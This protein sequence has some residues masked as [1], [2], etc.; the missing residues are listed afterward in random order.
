MSSQFECD[1]KLCFECGFKS[2][3][4]FWPSAFKEAHPT[5][6]TEVRRH[7]GFISDFQKFQEEDLYELWDSSILKRH[8]ETQENSLKKKRTIG[9]TKNPTVQK[10]SAAT[11]FLGKNEIANPA[12]K[13]GRYQKT[14]CFIA[15]YRLH[16]NIA[17]QFSKFYSIYRSIDNSVPLLP[18]FISLIQTAQ[19]TEMILEKLDKSEKL[20]RQYCISIEMFAAYLSA[21]I[22]LME[23]DATC[24]GYEAKIFKR[25]WDGLLQIDSENANENNDTFNATYYKLLNNE[26]YKNTNEI[27]VNYLNLLYKRL[28]QFIELFSLE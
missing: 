12:R 20:N 15:L 2:N 4:G 24:C 14:E 8:Q 16:L 9:P 23:G 22:S 5:T 26:K 11:S 25:A 13:D 21:V 1:A 27:D 17:E 7:T 6:S 28:N 3:T 19:R 18:V 10:I